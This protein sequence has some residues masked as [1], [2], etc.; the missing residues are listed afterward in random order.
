MA[1]EKKLRLLIKGFILVVQ[2]FSLEWKAPA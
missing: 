1:D 2:N